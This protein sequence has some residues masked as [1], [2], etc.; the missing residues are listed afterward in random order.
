MSAFDHQQ[1]QQQLMRPDNVEE[2]EDEEDEEEDDEEQIQGEYN[3]EY[4]GKSRTLSMDSFVYIHLTRQ[5]RLD[6]EAF[7]PELEIHQWQ[8]SAQ[9]H[10]AWVPCDIRP[11]LPFFCLPFVS[12]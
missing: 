2:E 8:L 3:E 5:R 7:H 4:Y 10:A 6:N 12:C 11:E 1:Q 9:D